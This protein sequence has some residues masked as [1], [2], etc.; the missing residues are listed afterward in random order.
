M[1]DH[2]RT[3]KKL[4]AIPEVKTFEEL[5]AKATLDETDKTLLRMYYLE[6]KNLGYIADTL[7][8]TKSAVKKRHARA[9][10][11]LMQIF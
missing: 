8:Y 10:D 11:K 4:K 5:L 9:L 1:T 6:R 3:R 7:G 2:I